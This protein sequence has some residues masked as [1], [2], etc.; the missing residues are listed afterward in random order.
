METHNMTNPMI[1]LSLPSSYIS[2]SFSCDKHA[3][4]GQKTT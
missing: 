4:Y 3:T 1:P 2:I